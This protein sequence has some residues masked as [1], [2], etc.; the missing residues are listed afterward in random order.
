MI[1][2]DVGFLANGMVD[3]EHREYLPKERSIDITLAKLKE[4]VEYKEDS[5][6]IRYYQKDDEHVKN[7]E[8][9]E[10]VA[11][12]EEYFSRFLQDEN[13]QSWEKERLYPDGLASLIEKVSDVGCCTKTVGDNRNLGIIGK[14]DI[15]TKDTLYFVT[16]RE[17]NSRWVIWYLNILNL[18]YEKPL[19]TILRLTSE[20]LLFEQN[21]YKYNANE[22]QELIRL[23]AKYVESL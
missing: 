1:G 5:T 4:Y 18:I 20:G 17:Y 23:C 7:S 9:I 3:K 2:Y 13:I 12:L 10:E 15:V 19:L 8:Y 11:M 16:T 6:D 14:A 21:I 22:E